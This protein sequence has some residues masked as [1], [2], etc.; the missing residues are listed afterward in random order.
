MR[1]P[2]YTLCMAKSLQKASPH[3]HFLCFVST[4]HM[5]TQ[6]PIQ[7]S[8]QISKHNIICGREHTIWGNKGVSTLFIDLSFCRSLVTWYFLNGSRMHRVPKEH[9]LPICMAG[10]TWDHWWGFCV[11]RSVHCPVPHEVIHDCDLRW[12]MD[13]TWGP[14][15]IVMPRLTYMAQNLLGLGT[16]Q[17]SKGWKCLPLLRLGL[18]LWNSHVYWAWECL[19]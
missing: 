13:V 10:F 7:F 8:S 15:I 5:P 9:D 19:K 6:F 14:S 4:K 2:D 1:L 17:A 11:L 12:H 18:S 16:W 3:L